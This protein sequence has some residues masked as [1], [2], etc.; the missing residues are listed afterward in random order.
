MRCS[1]NKVNLKS[2]KSAVLSSAT[3]GSFS[4][5]A[6]LSHTARAISSVSAV[7]CIPGPVLDL[8]ENA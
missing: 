4:E 1:K 8:E 3:S 7:D 6:A 5:V 2:G